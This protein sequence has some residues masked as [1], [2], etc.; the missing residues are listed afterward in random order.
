MRINTFKYFVVDASKS[1]KRNATISFAS[2]ITVAATLFIFGVFLLVMGNANKMMKSVTSQVEIKVFLKLDITMIDQNNIENALKEDN[3]VESVTYESREQALE[4]F[5]DMMGEKN[6]DILDGY[7]DANNPMQ[8]S[9]IV[10]LKAPEYAD[11]VAS[12][13]KDMSGIDEVKNDRDL[14]GIII[15]LSKAARWIGISMFILLMGVSLFLIGNTIRLTV[16][17]RRREIGIMKFVGATDWFIRWPFIIEGMVIGMIG[18]IISNLGLY[19]IYNV[20]FKK[21][22]NMPMTMTLSLMDPSYVLNA[23]S[24]QFALA[25]AAIGALGSIIALRKFLAV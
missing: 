18:A 8:A 25:G 24:W 7:T 17:S 22:L 16:F 13:I 21:L 10:K 4:K 14:V 19:A 12:R 9:Y 5:K 11:T 1:L 3:Q 2:V 6:K 15:S 20:A 23:L